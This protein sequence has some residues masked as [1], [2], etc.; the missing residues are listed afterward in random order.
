VWRSPVVLGSRGLAARPRARSFGR[1]LDAG[2]PRAVSRRDRDSRRDR[3]EEPSG[4]AERKSHP[5]E[6]SKNYCY[7]GAREV[8]TPRD[9]ATP[10]ERSKLAAEPSLV[11]PGDGASEGSAWN[12]SALIEALPIATRS[13]REASTSPNCNRKAWNT[14]N[15]PGY[16]LV[17][18]WFYFVFMMTVI[19]EASFGADRL[20]VGFVDPALSKGLPPHNAAALEFARS[21]G[22]VTRLGAAS[23][24]CWRDA[25]NRLRASEQFDVVW[26][27]QGDDPAA[28]HLGRAGGA[29]LLAWLEGG[30]ALLLSGAAGHL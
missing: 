27:H 22:E 14:M 21:V 26:F 12:R 30:G 13:V 24:G 23:E 3:A 28:A 11:T 4:R 29:D 15:K 20:R 8:T 17:T 18:S 2:A 10:E 1:F 25:D 9:S 5:L 19:S 7:V 6:R 16:A